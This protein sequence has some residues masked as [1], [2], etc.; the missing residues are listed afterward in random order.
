MS[1][2]PTKDKPAA[3][4][5]AKGQ[6]QASASPA[7]GPASHRSTKGAGGASFLRTGGCLLAVF[8][9]V[10]LLGAVA[11]FYTPPKPAASFGTAS[12]ADADVAP[13]IPRPIVR[14]L[15]VSPDGSQVA[16]GGEDAEGGRYRILLARIADGRFV[17]RDA[18]RLAISAHDER[19]L[20]LRFRPDGQELLSASQDGTVGRWRVEDG[21]SLGTLVPPGDRSTLGERRGLLALAVSDDGRWAAAGGWSG[22]VFVW[23]LAAPETPVRVLPGAQGPWPTDPEK[24]M[25]AGHV[26]EVRTLV[27]VA[28]DPPL[29]ISGGGEGLLVGWDL[30]QGKAGRVVST[31]GKTSNVRALLMRQIERGRDAEFVIVA[32]M[33][34]PESNG[35]LAAD[36]RGC[37]FLLT[38]SPPC[39]DWWLGADVPG[40]ACLRPLLDSKKICTPLARPPGEAAAPF[41]ALA[42]YPGLAGGFAGITLDEHFRLFRPRDTL[43]WR[44]FAGAGERND[45]M[46]ALAAGPDGSFYVVGGRQGQLRL[47]AARPDPTAPDI[48]IVD[49]LP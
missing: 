16:W 2:E 41:F 44:E 19:I 45:S 20:A 25:P 11:I 34:A 26:E 7:A 30:T 18:P 49:H 29:L 27:F 6:G 40:T 1:D 36:Y 3:T 23:D 31:D 43:P 14:A 38:T 17:D 9:F 12:S 48:R 42:R 15:A 5:P 47:Y 37:V 33:P 46:S 8:A 13:A 39:R 28:G 24:I 32:T 4:I 10:I 22:D 35:V 21:A